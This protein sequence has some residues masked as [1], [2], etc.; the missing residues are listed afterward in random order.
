[1]A[2][3]INP[4]ILKAKKYLGAVPLFAS[5]PW[6]LS[7]PSIANLVTAL[8]ISVYYFFCFFGITYIIRYLSDT[9]KLN[10]KT[11][12]AVAIG[13]LAFMCTY[14]AYYIVR[15]SGGTFHVESQLFIFP[16]A[17]FV[18]TIFA[19]FVMLAILRLVKYGDREKKED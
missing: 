17:V 18:R 6:F 9:L 1:M 19:T 15:M 5:M 16:F 8:V 13:A 3:K 2:A 10:Q 11:L 14:A 4:K 7:R 12:D